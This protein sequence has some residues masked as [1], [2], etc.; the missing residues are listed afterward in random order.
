MDQTP[1]KVA[2]LDQDVET[3]E[4]LALHI[5]DAIGEAGG[6]IVQRRDELQ[7]EAVAAWADRDQGREHV[8]R[9]VGIL[10]RMG[11]KSTFAHDADA[12]EAAEAWAA[13]G[14]ADA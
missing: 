9:L 5:A 8:R 1:E 13:Q 10:D 4:A 3:L 6:K 7:R 2:D 11:W 14:D 12:V